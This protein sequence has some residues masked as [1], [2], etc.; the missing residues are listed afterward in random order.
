MSL[1]NDANACRCH[2]GCVEND[3]EVDVSIAQVD[4]SIVLI[5]VAALAFAGLVGWMLLKFVTQD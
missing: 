5:V 2:A 3:A 1:I 4:V